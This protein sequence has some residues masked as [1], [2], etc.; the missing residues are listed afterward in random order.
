MVRKIDPV[1]Q[2]LMWWIE[3]WTIKMMGTVRSFKS[4]RRPSKLNLLTSF[5][6]SV[7]R[8]LSVCIDAPLNRKMYRDGRR[9]DAV[10]PEEERF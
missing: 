10:R 7:H 4:E 6:S 9:V 1:D 3:I 2:F 5:D 8:G